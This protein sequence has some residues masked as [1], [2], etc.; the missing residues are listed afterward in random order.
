[1]SQGLRNESHASLR[2]TVSKSRIRKR[3]RT[4]LCEGRP[5]IVVPTVTTIYMDV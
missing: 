1:M 2:V 4:D 3:A 5:A